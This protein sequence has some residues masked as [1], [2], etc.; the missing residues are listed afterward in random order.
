[1]SRRVGRPVAVAA[2]VLLSAV[3]C[4]ADSATSS[5]PPEPTERAGHS[6]CPQP[7]SRVD[8]WHDG[9]STQLITLADGST[10]PVVRGGVYP[11]PDYEGNPWSQWGQGIVLP[12]GRFLSAIGDH[13]G[14]DGNAHFYEFDPAT[15]RLTQIADVLSLTDHQSGDWGYGKIHAQMIAGPCGEAYAATYWGTRRDLVYGGSYQGDLL[16]RLDPYQ[17][18]I[19][20]LG[21]VL[22]GHGVP[23][24]AGWADGGLLYAEAPL[25]QP[26]DPE[27]GA[28]VA[29]DMATGD[30]VFT[31]ADEADHQGFRAMAVDG[32]GR[33]LFS[34]SGGRL[35][36]WDPATEEVQEL[37]VSLPGSFLRAA[38]SPAPN[39]TIYGVTQDPEVLFALGTDERIRDLG[40]AAGY[41]AS[42]ALS[43]DGNRLWYVPGAHGNSPEQGT[44]VIEVDT[45][46]G[47]QRVL[48]ELDPLAR[49]TLGLSLG[50]TYNVAVDAAGATLYLGMNA[51]PPGADTL[52]GE[53][54]I[55]IVE[56]E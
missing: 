27:R 40:A 22:D 47:A 33:V 14:R 7:G 10:G 50:G 34:R 18:T 39:G 35:A 51:A 17:R 2:L 16:L 25:P 54:V 8:A 38:T 9:P 30:R 28:L 20:N 24:M 43:P 52:F 37:D 31:T 4:D 15:D 56:L 26:T 21:P 23:S 49:D 29:L 32:R 19:E 11:R 6:S 36:R 12:D 41:T 5:G 13:L 1:M 48:V 3:R 55:I 44:P 42:L 46:T 53:V 45:H